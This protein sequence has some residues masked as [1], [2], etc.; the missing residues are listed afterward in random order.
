[1]EL[2]RLDPLAP[3]GWPRPAVAVGNFDGVH[4]GHQA[5]VATAVAVARAGTVVA[6]TFDP[7]PARVLAPERAPRALMTLEQKA[8]A[9]EAAGVQRLAVLPFTPEVSR[10]AAP[11]FARRVLR[12]SLGAEVVVVGTGFRFGHQRAG[13]SAELERLGG[14][15]GFRVVA[16][17]PVLLQ[18]EPVSSSRIREAL[19]RGQVEAAA[20]MLGRPFFVEG[21][22]VT[23]A[24][25]GRTLGVP[26]AN[27]APENETLPAVGVYACR[28]RSE[29]SDV[30]RGA[31]VNL[32][33]RPTWGGGETRLEA[34]LLD[35]E[36]DL[37]GARLRVE[38]VA[39]LR[40]ERAFPGPEALTAQ[41]SE[42]ITAAR[43]V[44]AR[45]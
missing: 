39:W 26:T 5:L 45:S 1:M 37:Y 6:L 44:L 42:D 19:A 36:G 2:V 17:P 29:E 12:E 35:F 14:E 20:E 25:R 33:R 7:H 10:L 9:L 34:H 32:G 22:V 15:F 11:E 27:L 23:G 21:L 30:V 13:D 4:R 24:G 28:C 43:V 18:G 8:E 31:V 41:I 3:C 16:H 38:F 40:E